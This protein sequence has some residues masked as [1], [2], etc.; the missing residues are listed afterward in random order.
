VLGRAPLPLMPGSE[1]FSKCVSNN[2]EDT[3]SWWWGG[4]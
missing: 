1:L 2:P 3:G 4:D